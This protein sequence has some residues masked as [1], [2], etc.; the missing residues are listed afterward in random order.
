M[1]EQVHPTGVTVAPDAQQESVA[2]LPTAELPTA[3][4][5][6]TPAPRPGRLR[7]L[8][9]LFRANLP[10]ALVLLVA[11]AAFLRIV[12]NHWRQGS[13]LL[14]GALLL[15]ALLRAL[16]PDDQTGLIVVRRSRLADVL[17]YAVLGVAMVFVALTLQ[18]GGPFDR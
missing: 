15:A 13:T 17:T 9:R 14:G 5:P 2:E 4:I 8:V 12:Q 3:E 7:G 6:V 16:L 10:F 18:P 11:A 1:A